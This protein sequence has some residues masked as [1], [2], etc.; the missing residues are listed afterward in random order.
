MKYSIVILLSS[1]ML[2]AAICTKKPDGPKE[3]NDAVVGLC[4]IPGE[5]ESGEK[6]LVKVHMVNR[7]TTTWDVNHKLGSVGGSRD[8]DKQRVLLSRPRIPVGGV[9]HFN[10]TVTAPINDT[11]D[12]KKVLMAWQMLEEHKEWFGEICTREVVVMPRPPFWKKIVDDAGVTDSDKAPYPANKYLADTWSQWLESPTAIRGMRRYMNMTE[13]GVFLSHD[14]HWEKYLNG[15]RSID[16]AIRESRPTFGQKTLSLY[17]GLMVASHIGVPV[18]LTLDTSANFWPGG[19]H[20]SSR[21]VSLGRVL[22]APLTRPGEIEKAKKLVG[23]LLGYIEKTWPGLV[24]YVWWENE[25]HYKSYT[26]SRYVEVLRQMVPIIRAKMPNVKIGIDADTDSKLNVS[27]IDYQAA[28]YHF[29]IPRESTDDLVR[30]IHARTAQLK[31]WYPGKEIWNDEFGVGYGW[32]LY[33]TRGRDRMI[34]GIKASFDAGV[35][36]VS[37]LVIGGVNPYDS[38][39]FAL[40]TTDRGESMTAGAVRDL[41]RNIGV[42]W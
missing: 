14:G 9:S 25:A 36:G 13:Y 42:A 30:N 12:S 35:K 23:D 38:G 21:C 41:A 29:A 39:E 7:G 19:Y 40:Y 6:V 18:L 3:G 26:K 24:K 2:T 22:C 28:G 10:F 4:E 31:A 1:I 16:Q 8:W 15:Q 33:T 11:D 32:D 20:D 34:R 27:G 17:D 5:V 37:F